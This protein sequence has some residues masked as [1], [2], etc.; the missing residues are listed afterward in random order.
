M[1]VGLAP[2]ALSESTI[3]GAPMARIF[4]PAR[5]AGVVTGFF[6][7]SIGLSP[8]LNQASTRKP[9][10]SSMRCASFAPTGPSAIAAM[11]FWPG[12]RNGICTRL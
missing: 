3:T 4:T 7:V 1:G 2:R 12:T 11:C 10:C 9:A 5:S 6:T 8:V